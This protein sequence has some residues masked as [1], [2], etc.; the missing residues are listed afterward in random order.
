L[1]GDFPN[2]AW[3]FELISP[4]NGLAFQSDG[5]LLEVSFDFLMAQEHPAILGE[6]ATRFGH[7]FPIRFDYLDTFE[8]GNLSVQC[9][10][11][12]EYAWRNFGERFDLY[13]WNSSDSERQ[14]SCE[15]P[16]I[17][18]GLEGAQRS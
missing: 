2:L 1:D 17:E 12:P 13:Q 8:G 3:S 7:E 14:H 10:P 16:C 5:R 18:W 11:R 9:H 6:F 4:E 15:G